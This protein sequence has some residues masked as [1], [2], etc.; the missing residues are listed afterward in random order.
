MDD[1][2]LVWYKHNYEQKDQYKISFGIYRSEQGI[3]ILLKRTATLTKNLREQWKFL[4]GERGEKV[5][6][7]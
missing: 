6:G 3:S 1:L 5:G 7:P 4:K 2:L